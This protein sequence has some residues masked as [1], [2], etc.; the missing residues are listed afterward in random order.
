MTQRFFSSNDNEGAKAPSTSLQPA[1]RGVDL[2]VVN[3]HA[4]IVL[5]S[6]EPFLD[7]ATLA[8]TAACM[9]LFG[10]IL[11]S[12]AG[13]PNLFN[14]SPASLFERNAVMLSARHEGK[15]VGTMYCYRD[16]DD[17]VFAGAAVDPA[18]SGQRIASALAATGILHD[19]TAFG[20]AR[21]VKCVVRQFV[22]GELNEPSKRSFSKLGLLLETGAET[23]HVKGDFSDRNLIDSAQLSEDGYA[24][25]RYRR[26]CG[27]GPETLARARLFLTAWSRSMLPLP[28]RLSG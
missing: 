18:H 12:N 20:P 5:N 8:K 13:R 26:M 25:I 21:D 17:L 2:S 10:R 11:R 15:V 7:A 1:I 23:H 19:F 3:L 22:N 28:M 27:G 24:S 14:Y 4:D 16:G 6:F 9:E